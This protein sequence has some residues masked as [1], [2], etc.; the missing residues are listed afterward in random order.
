MRIF[1]TTL[2]AAFVC[3]ASTVAANASPIT[4]SIN[5]FTSSA[6]DAVTTSLGTCPSVLAA[7]SSCS[8]SVSPSP[9]PPPFQNYEFTVTLGYT[10]NGEA[11]AVASAITSPAEFYN[12]ASNPPFSFNGFSTAVDFSN[13]D[14]A[15]IAVSNAA[16]LTFGVSQA[17]AVPEPFTLAL[18]GSGLAGAIAMRRRK[19]KVA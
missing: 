13:G 9:L 19:K 12:S 5:G 17:A 4:L 6:S 3:L 14:I 2:V 16:I 10:I 7:G 8:L 11:G 1:S 15:T 18:F